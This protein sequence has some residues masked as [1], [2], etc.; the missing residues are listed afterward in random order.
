MDHSNDVFYHTIKQGLEK[1]LH[2]FI[3]GSCGG[4][5]QRQSELDDEPRWPKAAAALEHPPYQAHWDPE[6]GRVAFRRGDL[7]RQDPVPREFT[8]VALPADMRSLRLMC[9]NL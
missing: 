9:S 2:S 6:R 4:T 7:V 8:L 3:V 1:Q 5:V